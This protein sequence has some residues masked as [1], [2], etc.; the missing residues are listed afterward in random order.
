M[1]KLKSLVLVCNWLHSVGQNHFFV[2]MHLNM[3]SAIPSSSRRFCTIYKPEK[4]DPLQ[5]SRQHNIPFGC[6]TVQ[7]IIRL[8]NKNFHSGPSSMSRSF[9][10]FQLASARMFQQHVRTTLSVRPAMRFL[11]KT[12]IWEDHCNRPEALI[13]KA[14]CAFKIQTS[15]RQPS[16]SERTIYLY[17]NCEDDHS[18]GPNARSPLIWKLRRVEVRSSGRQGN[19]VQMRLKLGKNFSKILESRSHSYPSERLMFTVR[20]APTFIKPDSHLNLQPINKGP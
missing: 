7:S 4:L 10:L 19:T 1:S 16:W 11:S 8:D 3:D 5:P 12:Q 18:I 14:S 20:T 2:M 17:G 6:P 13:H 15:E 9:K